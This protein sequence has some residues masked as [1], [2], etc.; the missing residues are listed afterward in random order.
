MKMSIEACLSVAYFTGL[1][2]G[3]W[4]QRE[5]FGQRIIEFVIP[6]WVARPAVG[7]PWF[8]NA[9]ETKRRLR[10]M[11]RTIGRNVQ[12][13]IVSDNK[14]SDELLNEERINHLRQF[15]NLTDNK[16]RLRHMRIVHPSVRQPE[17]KPDN[18][19]KHELITDSRVEHEH[20]VNHL[21]VEYWCHNF[22]SSRADGTDVDEHE[23]AGLFLRMLAYETAAARYVN[24]FCQNNNDM[25]RCG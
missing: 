9:F 25:R 8:N 10:A 18:C 16:K 3:K 1:R 12:S 5:M 6:S 20:E 4:R 2:P 19:L 11:R 22:E 17:T 13:A 23:Q 15:Q 21:A 7:A 14:L 24:R